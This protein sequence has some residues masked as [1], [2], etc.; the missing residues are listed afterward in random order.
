MDTVAQIFG[1]TFVGVILLCLV[2]TVLEYIVT[3]R[4]PANKL[5]ENMKEYDRQ[6]R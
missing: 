3:A 4:R 6:K 1:M 5:E 2:W